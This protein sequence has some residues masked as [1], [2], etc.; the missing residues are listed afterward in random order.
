[1]KIKE[2]YDKIVSFFEKERQH[3]KAEYPEAIQESIELSLFY[4]SNIYP[5][6][7]KS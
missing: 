2:Q 1:M 4:L 6:C 3:W 7:T 5:T